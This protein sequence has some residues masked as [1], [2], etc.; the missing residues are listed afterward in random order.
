M[1]KS[2]N[3]LSHP[4]KLEHNAV[5]ARDHDALGVSC[6]NGNYIYIDPSTPKSTQDSTLIHE[7]IEQ[8]NFQLNINLEHHQICLLETGL[9]QVLTDNKM[10][11]L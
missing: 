5:L 10:I 3:I 7:I 4:Y 2:L 11:T 8:L 6:G 1:K 9:Y